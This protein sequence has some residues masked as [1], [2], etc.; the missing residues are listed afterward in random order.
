VIALGVF[1]LGLA[2]GNWTD[3]MVYAVAVLVVARRVPSV[4]D[5]DRDHGGHGM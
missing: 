5:T 1:R 4:Q 2:A 3:A